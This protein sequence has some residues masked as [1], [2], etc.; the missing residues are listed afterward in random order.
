MA[1]MG[2]GWTASAI[3]GR[4][5]AGLY[6]MYTGGEANGGFHFAV[7]LPQWG[8]SR[9]VR[10]RLPEYYQMEYSGQS[11][12]EVF[13][14]ETAVQELRDSADESNSVPYDG[15]RMIYELL[16]KREMGD[17]YCIINNIKFYF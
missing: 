1:T 13:P 4:T 2:C 6:A 9:K 14:P 16:L 7:P 5:T 17:E 15:R 8:K 10:V 3:F 12:L 11:G